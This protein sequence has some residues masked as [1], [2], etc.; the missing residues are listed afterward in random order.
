MKTIVYSLIEVSFDQR[1]FEA[2]LGT[3]PSMDLAE[4]KIKN[5]HKTLVSL[6]P[7]GVDENCG[8]GDHNW[9]VPTE[10]EL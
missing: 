10:L 4:S 8:I 5:N 9:I 3:Y 7:I 1:R 6:E 2:Y